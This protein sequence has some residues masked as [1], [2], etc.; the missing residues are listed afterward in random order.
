[1][2]WQFTQTVRWCELTFCQKLSGSKNWQR[3][4]FVR[5]YKL[6]TYQIC[7]VMWT[8]NFPNLSGAESW[9]CT[10]TIQNC[11]VMWADNVPKLSKPVRLCELTFCKPVRCCKLTMYQICQVLWTAN[12][13]NLSGDVNS[14]FTQTVRCCKLTFC[15]NCQMLKADNISIFSGDVH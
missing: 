13:P 9:Q 4:K 8:Y 14:Q 6:I 12:I 10:K 7:Q 15:Q 3:T 1:M 11:Q 2:N 5:C